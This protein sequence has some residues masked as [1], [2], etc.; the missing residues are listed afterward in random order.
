MTASE[1]VEQR[2]GLLYQKSRDSK[3]FPL[4]EIKLAV[5]GFGRR[6]K[7]AGLE[8]A[9]VHINPQHKEL[10]SEQEIAALGLE[11]EFDPNVQLGYVWLLGRLPTNGSGNSV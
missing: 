8:P 3:Q 4:T 2:W 7:F 11:V 10:V 5:R 9:I 1:I 6:R